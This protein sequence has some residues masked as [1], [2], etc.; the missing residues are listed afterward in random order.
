MPSWFKD[1]RDFCNI[2]QGLR[3]VGFSEEDVSKVMGGN[4]YRFFKENFTPQ[5]AL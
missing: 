4:W 3:D 1:N 5:G 2:A